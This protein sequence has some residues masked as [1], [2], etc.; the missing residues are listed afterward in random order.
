MTTDI[1]R[2]QF[3]HASRRALAHFRFVAVR[4]VECSTQ[5]P[6][7]RALYGLGLCAFAHYWRLR[8]VLHVRPLRIG[9]QWDTI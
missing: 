2:L 9:P 3:S 7:R 6:G 4:V 5:L 8:A 1:T